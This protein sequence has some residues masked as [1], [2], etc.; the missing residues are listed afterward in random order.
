MG[1]SIHDAAKTL[2]QFR[3]PHGAYLL[4]GVLEVDRAVCPFEDTC[5]SLAAPGQSKDHAEALSFI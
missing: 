2:L 5:P 3:L 4:L 1:F